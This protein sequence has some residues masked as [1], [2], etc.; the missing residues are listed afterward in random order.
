MYDAGFVLLVS[1]ALLLDSARGLIAMC[2][3]QSLHNATT[4]SRVSPPVDEAPDFLSKG[5]SVVQT[6]VK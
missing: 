5:G 3:P 1:E 6:H 4:L 2:L